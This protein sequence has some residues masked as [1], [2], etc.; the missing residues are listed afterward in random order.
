MKFVE[1]M[2][3]LHVQGHKKSIKAVSYLLCVDGQF[4]GK[5]YYSNP[6]QSSRE[7]Y[8]LQ[9]YVETVPM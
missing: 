5:Y 4:I 6:V 7:R 3:L 2:E 9:L 8:G 1:N